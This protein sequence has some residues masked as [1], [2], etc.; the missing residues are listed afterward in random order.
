M[1]VFKALPT[2]NSMHQVIEFYQQNLQLA[3]ETGNRRDEM[4][5]LA[6]LGRAHEALEERD[7]AIEFYEL[8]LKI[9][10]DLGDGRAERQT[11]K[12]LNDARNPKP[13]KSVSKT[14]ASRKAAKKRSTTAAK[15]SRKASP[16]QYERKVGRLM[17]EQQTSSPSN[18]E[19]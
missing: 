6:S 19:E 1:I 15:K 10:G 3:R 13:A 7:K 11:L 17:A 12:H 14:P 5:A 9:A 18:K 8:A 4:S 16:K 2:D